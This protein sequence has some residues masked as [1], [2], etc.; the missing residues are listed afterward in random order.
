MK[1]RFVLLFIL[2]L[3]AGKTSPDTW[4]PPSI[5][6]YLSENGQFLLK[7]YP[8]EIPKNYY[9]WHSAKPKRKSRFSVEDTTIVHCHAILY[10]IN[11]TDTI[12]IWNKRLINRMAPSFA[13]VADDGKSVVTFDNWGS[14][15]AGIDVMVTYG[16]CGNMVKRYNLEEFSPFPINNYLMSI[17]S[18]W[19][20]CGAKYI[21]NDEIEICFSDDKEN[22]ETRIYN[23]STKEFR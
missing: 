20:R 10:E 7:V 22:T 21:S 17:S 4:A 2:V 11:H 13:I 23:L 16:E 3:L 14:L 9:K 1:V 15:G 6:S 18:I 19:W 12:Q 5:R 8:T